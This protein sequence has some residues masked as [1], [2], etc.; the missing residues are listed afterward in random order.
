MSVELEALIQ[1]GGV[2]TDVEGSSY[3]EVYMNIVEKMNFSNSIS[4]DDVFQALCER[5]KVMSTA[6]GNG[7]AIPHCRIPVV[8][9]QSEQCVAVACLKQSLEMNA[10][11]DQPVNCMFVIIASNQSD[12]IQ[13]LAKIAE[14]MKNAEFRKLLAD[15][16]SEAEILNAVKEFAQNK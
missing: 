4:K 13:I 3:S 10:P 16:A 8:K 7:I 1:K 5:E 12:H 6:V 11:D 9:E 2:Y 14:L 15:H